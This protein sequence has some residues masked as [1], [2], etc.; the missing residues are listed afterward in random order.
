MDRGLAGD[1]VDLAGGG[2]GAVRAVAV[3]VGAAVQH[4][5]PPP[6]GLVTR[7]D[8]GVADEDVLSRPLVCD[9]ERLSGGLAEGTKH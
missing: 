6:E 3:V 9:E 8:A 7:V 1:A 4:V 2:A 5:D